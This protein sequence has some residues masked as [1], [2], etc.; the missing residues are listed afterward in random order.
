LV[1]DSLSIKKVLY[2]NDRLGLP[3]VKLPLEWL[4]ILFKE[5]FVCL[6]EFK[7]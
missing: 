2:I 4:F 7:T 5:L 6:I 1:L 3:C